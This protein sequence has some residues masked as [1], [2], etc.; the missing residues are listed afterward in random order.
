MGYEQA[1]L[2]A[3]IE[4]RSAVASARE[5]G[6]IG[7]LAKPKPSCAWAWAICSPSPRTTRS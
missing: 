2:T 3:V 5:R 1:T 6:D 7:A 4:A